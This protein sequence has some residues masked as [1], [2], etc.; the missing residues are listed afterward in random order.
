VTLGGRIERRALIRG[1]VVVVIAGVALRLA[2]GSGRNDIAG[3]FARRGIRPRQLPYVDRFLEYPVVVGTILWVLSFVARTRVAMWMAYSFL[4]TGLL[5]VTA[6]A[7]STAGPSASRRLLVAPATVCYATHNFDLLAVA[8]ATAAL[9][10]FERGFMVASGVLLALGTWAKLYPAVIAACLAGWLFVARRPAAALRLVGAFGATSVAVNAP[11]VLASPSGW[12]ATYSFHARRLPSW[13]SLWFYVVHDPF[14]HLLMGRAAA[15]TTV[16]IASASALAVAAV[17]VVWWMVR[18]RPPA[19]SACLVAVIVFMLANKVYSPQYDLW[20]VPLLC[21]GGAAPVVF[22]RLAIID[23][24]IF[25]DVFGLPRHAASVSWLHLGEVR[26]AVM[27]ALVIARAL[28]L[29]GVV[30]AAA[31]DAR[32]PSPAGTPGRTPPRGSRAALR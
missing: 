18:R 6:R 23:A 24:A 5:Y 28:T 21:L 15:R 19:I 3:L 12:W 30:V 2:L 11:Y 13:G 25:V 31:R 4:A 8:P 16:N 9:V 7:V 1:V 32:V 27:F 22:R 29:G 10:A 17:A 20:L 26:T 14:H